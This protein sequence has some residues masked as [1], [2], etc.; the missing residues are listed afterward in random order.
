MAIPT[1]DASPG[2]LALRPARARPWIAAA[3]YDGLQLPGAPAN[4]QVR[5][6]RALGS[7]VVEVP[8][9]ADKAHDELWELH[10]ASRLLASSSPARTRGKELTCVRSL[11]A[12]TGQPSS[13]KV[14]IAIPLAVT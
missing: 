12:R 7:G 2:E 14:S 1:A 3:V 4:A 10:I 11:A 9:A 8:P 13:R 5:L 6:K